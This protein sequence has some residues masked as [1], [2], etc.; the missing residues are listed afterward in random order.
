MPLTFDA[1]LKDLGGDYPSDFL[2]A[3]DDPPALPVSPLNVDLSAVTTSAD[4]VLGLGDPLQEVV[5]LDFQSSASAT[6]HAE[7]LVYNALLF[8][9]Y[10]VPVHSVVVLLRPQ[11]AHANLSGAVS[12]AARPNRGKMDFGYELVRLWERPAE[13][14]LAGALGTAP[15]A[16]LGR[17]PEGVE[18][19]PGLTGL[20]QRLIQRLE[21]EAP[22]D[23][24]RKLLTTA[25]VLT[26][27]RVQR[28]VARQV[29]AGGVR[30]MRDSDTYL[31]ILDEGRE[32]QIKKDILR[33]G[34]KRFGP[35]DA[36]GVTR[37][38]AITDLDRLERLHDRLLEASGW[39]DLF[40]T[41]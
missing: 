12:Y 28:A 3:F 22:A 38:H 26:G 4:L 20:A 19:V 27:L 37:L 36:T 8:K 35:A 41:P 14:L 9:Q 15:L 21:R 7:V 11:A 2:S 33:L 39:Q 34:Q 1:S 13:A 31:A 25:F 10:R 32:D 30:A 29:F 16:L 18:L 6:K 24:V 17:L 5:H 23:Q 40:D